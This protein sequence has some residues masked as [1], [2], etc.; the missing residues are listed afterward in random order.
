M[1]LVYTET[2]YFDAVVTHVNGI[3]DTYNFNGRTLADPDN[4][5]DLIPKDTG[6]FKFP[7]FGEN[8]QVTIEL[9]NSQP[10]ECSFGSVEW[11]A[12]YF[13]KARRR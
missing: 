4:I 2:T 9:K 3:T 10:Y 5:V 12:M 1:S 13:P 8:Q 7:V 6:E 11:T